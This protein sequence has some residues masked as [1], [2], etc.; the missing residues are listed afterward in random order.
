MIRTISLI[1][2]KQSDQG[3]F[4]RI[5]ID[6]LT[7]LKTGELPYRDVNAD[8]FSDS[9]YSRIP[10][11]KYRCQFTISMKFP[12]GS[13]QLINVE[14]NHRTGVR[15]HKGNWCGDKRLGYYSDVEGCILLGTVV[16]TRPCEKNR[17]KPQL[18]VFNSTAAYGIFMEKMSK[19]PFDLEI[20]E[21]FN[22]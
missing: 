18:G 8:G 4:G 16:D 1:R 10:P 11:G 6:P 7:T 19:N 17:N 20:I 21:E 5:I 14:N 9:N 2:E 13:F 12:R 3:T 22:T 15:I